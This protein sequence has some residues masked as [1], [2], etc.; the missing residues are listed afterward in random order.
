MEKNPTKF[1]GKPKLPYYKNKRGRNLVYF[2]SLQV[3][4][5]EGYV[6]LTRKMTKLGFSKIKTR[7]GLKFIKGVRI[8]P[9]GDRSNI[10]LIYS[11]ELTDLG[12]DKKNAIG[13]DLGLN[14]IITTSDNIGNQP[15]I[16][17]G[18]VL[19]SINQFY[20]KELA[21]YR[22][23]SAICN[24]KHVTNRILKIH[25]KRNNKVHDF[26]HKI[27][28]KII[29]YCI[30]YNI[31]SIVIG[32]NSKLKQNIN[33]GKRN[34]QNFVQVPFLKFVKQVE[35][36]A[37][38][39]GIEVIRVFEDFTSQMCSGC[40]V[41]DKSNRKHRGLYV[42]SKCGLM[43]NADVNASKNI[44]R[45]GIPKSKSIWLGDRGLLDRPVVL[46]IS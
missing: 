11:C 45:K 8:I 24:K 26:F 44:L 29:N 43:L 31:G 16:I 35:Y 7:P 6:F 17:K 10:E 40:G 21:K 25:R 39:V 23:L 18:G 5:K 27:S 30:Q 14:N 4:I 20:N 33:I 15:L 19:K 46:K 3:R 36:K 13:I 28:R 37:L 41:V 42:C 22:S 34:N 38:L 12:L 9:F 2:T 1:L 32:Y